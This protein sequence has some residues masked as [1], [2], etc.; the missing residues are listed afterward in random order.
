MRQAESKSS[1]T[2]TPPHDTA[3]DE[4]TR[5]KNYLVYSEHVKVGDIILLCVFDPGHALFL[6]NQFTDIL[7]HK[8]ALEWEDR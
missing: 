2:G 1:A 5:G 7:I 4:S 8:L 3:H 6:V